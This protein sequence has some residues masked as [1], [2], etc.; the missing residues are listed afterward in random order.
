[1]K[2]KSLILIAICV[3]AVSVN[4]ALVPTPAAAI[5]SCELAA[6]AGWH[7]PG[8]NTWCFYDILIRLWEGGASLDDLFRN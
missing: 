7:H 6:A 3:L 4:S 5:D 1:M 2:T 8:L